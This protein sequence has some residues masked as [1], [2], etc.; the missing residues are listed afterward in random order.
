[1]SKK[2]GQGIG[3]E[4]QWHRPK[5]EGTR[6][7][8]SV[9]QSV[10]RIVNWKEVNLKERAALAAIQAKYGASDCDWNRLSL[11]LAYAHEPSLQYYLKKNVGRRTL[12]HDFRAGFL[13]WD[14]VTLQ[15]KRKLSVSSACKELTKRQRWK[16]YKPASLRI[17]FEK[18]AKRST[19]AAGLQRAIA[20]LGWDVVAGAFRE[21]LASDEFLS[22]CDDYLKDL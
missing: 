15:Q 1:L 19:F 2:P 14:V 7:L 9:G 16:G 18:H 8:L 17:A 12:W 13:W 21:L 4:M 6:S 3:I 20:T 22:H 11:A 10:P 5:E